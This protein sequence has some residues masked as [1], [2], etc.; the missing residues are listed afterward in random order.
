MPWKKKGRNDEAEG[1]FKTGPIDTW[2]APIS[3]ASSSIAH[4]SLI[5]RLL[6]AGERRTPHMCKGGREGGRGHK[7]EVLFRWCSRSSQLPPPP[8]VSPTDGA[9]LGFGSSPLVGVEDP[10]EGE[11][12]GRCCSRLGEKRSIPPPLP[13]FHRSSVTPG[14]RVLRTHQTR[15][16]VG[17]WGWEG[18]W[19]GGVGVEGWS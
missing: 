2:S 11:K 5:P 17:R 8:P 18:E 7:D 9:W 14:K 12:G 13:A 6:S 15:R 10:G 3:S 4:L 1:G 19:N 16:G